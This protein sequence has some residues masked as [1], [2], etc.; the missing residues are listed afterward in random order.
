M[1][2]PLPTE[3]FATVRDLVQGE[4]HHMGAEEKTLLT[5]TILI[6]DGVYCGRRFHA[7]G[8]EAIWFVEEGQI[9]FFGQDGAFSHVTRL[10]ESRRAEAA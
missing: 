4:F 2:S 8:L 7:E 6:R 3:S 1:T 9:K 5:E 10:A